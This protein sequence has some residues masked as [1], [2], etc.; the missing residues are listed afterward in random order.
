M[1][2]FL[3]PGRR[4]FIGAFCFPLIS[5][6]A[7]LRV[8]EDFSLI[9]RA[10]AAAAP[11][12]T[13][14]IAPG[15]YHEN[16]FINKPLT[17][18]G[19]GS[20]KTTIIAPNRLLAIARIEYYGPV[21]L[22]DL[23][24]AHAS[25]SSPAERDV[26]TY[27]IEV[28]DADITLRNLHLAH[29]AGYGIQ[30]VGGAVL[31][32]NVSVSGTAFNAITLTDP[33]P[34]VRVT[35]VSINA[36][37]KD[38]PLHLENVVGTFKD[39]KLSLPDRGEIQVW[40]P[41]TA[42]KFENL[43]AEHFAKI[44]WLEGATANDP[45]PVDPDSLTEH[46]RRERSERRSILNE[47]LA[48]KNEMD[49]KRAVAARA[50]EKALKTA[51]TP[52]AHKAAVTQYIRAL[53]AIEDVDFNWPS[54]SLP[55]LGELNAYSDRFGP[56]ALEELLQELPAPDAEPG[57]AANYILYLP[58]FLKD[59]IAK[60]NAQ[61]SLAS[62]FDLPAVLAT[63]KSV[64]GKDPRAVANAFADMVKVVSQKS[65]ASTADE[66]QILKSAVVAEISP[67]IEARGYAAL[68]ALIDALAAKPVTLLSADEVR[69]AMTPQQKRVLTKHLLSE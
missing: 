53:A 46:Y 1:L 39:V 51:T 58:A 60:A 32:E 31:I 13:V 30:C 61:K 47:A 6:A 40:G 48:D 42:I 36:D 10:I 26:A 2:R 50:F 44:R 38:H 22:T 37:T 29:S 35:H 49:A 34:G 15:A 63:W 68:S 17:L 67:F 19:A 25:Q 33:K 24:L 4:F 64:D 59:P 41:A 62:A 23:A 52:A 69:A 8:P 3:F 28:D 14:V 57:M 11:N 54:A 12:D 56:L 66:K 9:Q 16:L 18:R 21:T 45:K 27:A 65:D 5:S 7:T 20:D 55:I 43:P